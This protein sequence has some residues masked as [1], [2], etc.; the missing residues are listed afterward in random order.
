MTILISE[1]LR[2]R[3][4][5]SNPEYDILLTFNE[6]LGD[7]SS[8]LEIEAIPLVKHSEISGKHF[9]TPCN[10]H[11]TRLTFDLAVTH[12][13]QSARFATRRDVLLPEWLHGSG[14]GS[15]I[16]SKLIAWGHHVAPAATF[17]QLSLS[18]VDA[19]TPIAKNRRNGFYRA[20]NFQLSF[21]QDPEERCG[22]CC[23]ATLNTLKVRP[24]NNRKVLSITP[25]DKFLIAQLHQR[26]EMERQVATQKKVMADWQ[27]RF[28]VSQN[29]NQ[30]LRFLAMVLLLALIILLWHQR[31]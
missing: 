29:K 12:A 21:S 28:A 9:T 8:H 26:Y 24:V 4:M 31:F 10:L 7:T 1:V 22:H 27:T 2:V 19:Q 6:T 25:V 14:L 15:Y 18:A 11:G 17:K 5:E 23:S 13:T 16:F 3:S 30:K 20:H